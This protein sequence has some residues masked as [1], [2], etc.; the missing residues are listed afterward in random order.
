L[1]SRILAKGVQLRLEIIPLDTGRKMLNLMAK[2]YYYFGFSLLIILSGIVAMFL[3][4]LKFSNDFKG[5]SLLEAKFAS[6]KTPPSSQVVQFYHEKGYPD[7]QVSTSGNDILIIRTSTM[8]Q[9]AMVTMVK[10]LSDKF[11]DQIT[12]LRFDNVGPTLAREVTNRSILLV[13][14]ASVVLAIYITLAFR[15]TPNSFRYGVCTVVA[16]VHDVLVMLSVAAITGYF[17][18]WEIDTLFLTATLTVIAFSAQDTIVVFDRIRENVANYRRLSFPSLV[19]HSVV[20]T[21]TR[22]INTQVMAVQF[23]LF[24]LVLFGGITLQRFA[25]FLLV[26]MLSGSYSS[27]FIAAPL[28]IIWENKEWRTWFRRKNGMNLAPQL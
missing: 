25:V 2:R 18:G 21:L 5:G 19:N 16:L 28:L 4:G 14:I 3:W 27:D 6:G 24:S 8:D 11:V 1:S 9:A 7:V 13:G 20:Q 26:G 15:S 12:T 17:W 10:S 23:I 22:T